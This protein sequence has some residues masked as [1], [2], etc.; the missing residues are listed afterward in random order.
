[1]ANP[2]ESWI[3]HEIEVGDTVG[4]YE[5]LGRLGRGGTA[6]VF[7]AVRRGAKGFSA[8]VALKLVDPDRLDDPRRFTDEARLA[9]RC[10]HP[11]V[12][13]AQDFGE[14]E[15]F[16]YL[17]TDYVHGLSLD[18]ILNELAK[19][20]LNLSIEVAGYIVC[21]VA[22]GLHAI[23]EVRNRHGQSLSVVHRD[24]TPSNIMISESGVVRIIDLG[25]ASAKT[26][27]AETSPGVVLGTWRYVSPEQLVGQ[28]AD[29]RA[30]VYSL[31]AVLWE[32]LTMQRHGPRSIEDL[33]QWLEHHVIDPP[34]NYNKEV[35]AELDELVG[36]TLTHDLEERIP[37]AR[38]LRRR[39]LRCIPRQTEVDEV[40]LASL[41]AA[42]AASQ[43][44][45][46]RAVANEVTEFDSSSRNAQTHGTTRYDREG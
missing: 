2:P 8:L 3:V 46:R 20:G 33:P 38:E 23:H 29:K 45:K 43:L 24:I 10:N 40:V 30:D 37:S 22:R 21:E 31:G 13:K 15:K 6:T 7:L 9:A 25:I 34:S 14:H 12:V 32:M 5:I 4:P 39:L 36:S 35:D 42:T 41:L 19:F 11:N 1:M 44:E 16:M 26:R 27:Q 17:A 28:K 18:M